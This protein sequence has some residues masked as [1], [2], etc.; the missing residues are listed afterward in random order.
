MNMKFSINDN[1]HLIPALKEYNPANDGFSITKGENAGLFD[2]YYI[3]WNSNNQFSLI[4][5]L[6]I[7]SCY[8][9]CEE[10]TYN[11]VGNSDNHHCTKCKDNYYA[12]EAEY[13]NTDFNCYQEEGLIP[14]YY[15]DPQDHNFKT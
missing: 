14:N 2:N 13:V 1:L 5:C 7:T 12:K 4:C 9:L 6:N 11:K 15:Y 10:C 3:Y 8:D